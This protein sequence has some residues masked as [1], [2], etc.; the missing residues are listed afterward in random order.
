MPITPNAAPD[1]A[2]PSPRTKIC[3]KPQRAHYDRA[4]VEAIVDEA[5][6]CFV[7]FNHGGSVHCLPMACWRFDEHLYLHAAG[8]ARMSKALLLGECAVSIAHLDGLVLAR[9]AF[10]HSM[11]FRSVAIYGRFEEVLDPA[12]KAAAFEAFV[13]HVSPRRAAQVRP[14]SPAEM[15]GTALLRLP[16]EEAA[17]KIRS[18]GVIDAAADMNLPVWAGVLPLRLQVGVPQADEGCENPEIPTL[19]P[20]LVRP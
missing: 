14:A 9:S 15:A 19:P 8:N 11:N 12:L 7:A 5:L 16:L 4:S 10:H 2:P 13:N 3:R 1:S 6:V 20:F 17:A 18:G